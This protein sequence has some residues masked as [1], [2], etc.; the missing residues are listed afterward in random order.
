M[1]VEFALTGA[2]IFD[3]ER[4]HEDKAVLVKGGRI[5]GLVAERQVAAHVPRTVLDGGILSP[6]FIDAQVNGGGGVM[7]NDDPSVA[8]MEAISGAH[9]AYG[10]TSLLPT[11]ITDR[12]P[13]IERAIE[14]AID[15]VKGE[16][17]IAGLHLEGPHLAP[18]RRGAHLAEFMRPVDD[19]DLEAY[20]S[21][22]KHLDTLLLTIAAEQVSP[23]QVARLTA[24][25]V[26][27]SLGHSDCSA[28]DATRLFDAGA[29]G[30][31]H[32]FNAMSQLG[33]RAPGLVGAALDHPD[34]WCGIV[35]DGHH[36]DPMTLRVAL[37]AKRG[38]HGKGRIFLV[39]D[40]MAL[41]GTQQSSFELNGRTITRSPGGLCPKLTLAD[42]T[43]AGSDLDMASA[44]GFAV[45][46]L[47]VTLAE[48]LAMATA[49]PARFLGMRDRGAIRA[50]L[51]ADFVHLDDRLQV[52]ATWRSGRNSKV[53]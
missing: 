52:T 28:D 8:A 13:V 46:A 40:A 5:A 43:I 39:T 37:R 7:L 49:Y 35:A 32:L 47:D 17:G 34:V 24:A 41:V 2:R 23:A 48:A 45:N 4:F 11:L 9:Q 16:A 50:G 15:A 19:R 12:Q 36:V 18:A 25:G 29:R 10:T 44:I 22:V 27:V 3:G 53:G 6:G 1:M 30:V 26:T 21:A 20:T 42:G 31:T 14:A 33:N 38:Q 51:R